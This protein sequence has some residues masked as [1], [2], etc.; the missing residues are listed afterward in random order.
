MAPPPAW[1]T[2]VRL[3]PAETEGAARVL[4]ST[5]GGSFCQLPR[6]VVVLPL[7]SAFPLACTFPGLPAATGYSI[8]RS[9]R[10]AP[11]TARAIQQA[12]AEQPSSAAAVRFVW[13]ALWTQ[14]RRRQV[15]PRLP[16]ALCRLLIARTAGCCCADSLLTQSA[17]ECVHAF[18]VPCCASDRHPPCP[19][20]PCPAATAH[21]PSCHC[22]P[23]TSFQ[24]FG[25][26]LLCQLDATNTA[27]FFTTF[28]RL[29]SSFWRGFL[30]SKLSSGAR[31]ALVCPACRRLCWA[32]PAVY[33]AVAGMA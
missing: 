4:V 25:M 22:L 13:E 1:C 5:L 12:L 11:K 2:Q 15:W 14:E 31:S 28:F 7:P 9:L 19:P 33:C 21:L 29:P 32:G 16:V 18:I 3:W 26:E 24:V 20:S 6:V 10:E 17:N 27:D 8:T 23:Q 30:A